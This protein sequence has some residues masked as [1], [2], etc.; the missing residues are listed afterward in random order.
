MKKRLLV[1]IVALQMTGMAS[2]VDLVLDDFTVVQ[3]PL[4]DSVGGAFVAST[5]GNRTIRVTANGPGGLGES[6]AAFIIDGGTGAEFMVMAN[7]PNVRGTTE[8]SY[9]LNGLSGLAGSSSGALSINYFSNFPSTFDVGGSNTLPTSVAV[10]FDGTSSDFYLLP[11]T[12]N[13]FAAAS[14]LSFAL[15]AA[16]LSSLSEAGDLTFIF[17][18]GLGYRLGLDSIALQA[19]AVSAVPE[20]EV[21]LQLALG[22]LTVAGLVRRRK[23]TAT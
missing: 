9:S 21:V 12:F 6:A 10:S 14:T 16:Q 19:D 2:A 4:L 11:Q 13:T 18:G 23:K 8:L 15:N 22:G 1:V 7:T 20:P 3:G 17:N 5:V